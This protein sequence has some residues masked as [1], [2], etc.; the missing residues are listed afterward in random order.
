MATT[1]DD[2]AADEKSDK[3]IWRLLNIRCT[4]RKKCESG[5]ERCGSKNSSDSFTCFEL[6]LIIL[7][8]HRYHVVCGSL[9]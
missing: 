7:P 3:S 5:K 2:N 1:I 9:D 4:S 8:N 6:F